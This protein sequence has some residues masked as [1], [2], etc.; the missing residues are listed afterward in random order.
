VTL[1]EERY[2]LLFVFR[3]FENVSYAL[4]VQASEPVTPRDVART[5]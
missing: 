4:V 3:T 1:P 2:G 5:P